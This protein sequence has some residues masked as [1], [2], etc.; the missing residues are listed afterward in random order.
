[1]SS[2]H[3]VAGQETLERFAN[4]PAFNRWLYQNISNYCSGRILEIGS[5]IGNISSLLLADHQRVTLSD[6]RQPYCDKLQQRFGQHPH[7]EGALQLDIAPSDFELHHPELLQQFDTVI[8]LNVVEHIQDDAS[9]LN[10]CK[11]LLRN[12]GRLIILV[13]AYQFLY[14]TFDEEL[15]HYKRYTRKELGERMRAAGMDLVHTRY[16]NLAGIPGW[17]LTGSVMKK[18]VIPGAQLKIFN[19]LVPIFRLLDKLVLSKVGL[20]AIAVAVNRSK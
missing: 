10:N 16:F 1:M 12:N 15:G 5:G 3:D 19:S 9:A 8:A 4:A 7:F 6:L 17:W 2:G 18:K 14:N 11:K 20:S 13:P